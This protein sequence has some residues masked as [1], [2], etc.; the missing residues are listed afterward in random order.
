MNVRELAAA[1]GVMTTY[2]DWA[3]NPKEVPDRT[4]RLVLDAL[5]AD[6]PPS[7][8]EG[9]LR[10]V[11]EGSPEAEG[12]EV[13][14][15]D[16]LLVAPRRCPTPPRS[17]GW[18]VQLYAARS[19]CSWGM[20]DL[21]D[22]AR[23]ARWSAGQG[24]GFVLVNPLHADSPGLPQ[25]PSPY[26]PASRRWRNPLY[27]AIE[28]LPEVGLL[29]ADARGEVL[30]L[31][32]E[33]RA[34]NDSEL[35]DRDAVYERKTRALALLH[36]APARP[37]FERW[38]REQGQSLEDFAT[39]CAL[40][41][42]NPGM[43][44]QEWSDSEAARPER[45]T[46]HAWLQWLC[47][48]QLAE[49]QRCA[50]EAGMPVGLIH[51]LAVGC[52]PGG[53]DAWAQRDVIAHGMTIGAPPDSFNRKGQDWRLP[54]WRP[55]R[56]R[57][58]G[59]EPFR[60]LVRGVLTDAG[61]IRVDH[62]M[63]LFRLFWVPDGLSPAEGAYV[64]YDSDA[65]LGILAYECHRAGAI[66]VAEDLGTVEEGVPETLRDNG[67]LGSAVLWFE[68]G[69]PATYPENA[70]ASV[71]THDLPTARGVWDDDE[72]AAEQETVLRL[73][74]AE[75]LVGEDPTRDELVVAMHAFVARTPSLLAA[76]ALGDALGDPRQPNMPGTKD[77]Y[78]NWRI[79]LPV[80]LDV[81]GDDERL[82]AVVAA[83]SEERAR[84]VPAG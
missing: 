60:D 41:E 38:R 83:V 54:P 73:L 69:G 59:Y 36:E 66:A 64:R 82:R 13:G 53:A 33:A 77:E 49:A 35:V 17:W 71:T 32:A 61:G 29:D 6:G 25:E 50:R 56:L 78:P 44:Y 84:Q 31:G 30:R 51:D 68:E 65:L 79:P 42:R 20:G 9:P 67:V 5:E 22:L 39:W 48:E 55:D 23:L 24:A 43:P 63:G 28:D 62:A 19:R 46:F 37:A 10:V 7:R 12:K 34:L 3:G 58:V 76:V 1:H 52:D 21:G 2:D 8:E 72:R 27:L 81:V 26:F 11:R 40:A 70:F 16:G 80:P 74:R 15:Y 45:V 47:A 57:E 4:L 18:M 75:G 14:E